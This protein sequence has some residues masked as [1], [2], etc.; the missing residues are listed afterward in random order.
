MRQDAEQGGLPTRMSRGL[1]KKSQFRLARL[2]QCRGE[3]IVKSIRS[4]HY[5]PAVLLF[6]GLTVVWMNP[7]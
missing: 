4:R 2:Q 7:M 3:G 5:C 1:L 6:I